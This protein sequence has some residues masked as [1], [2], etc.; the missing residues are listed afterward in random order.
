MVDISIVIVNYK[1]WN[2]LKE[3]LQSIVSIN[4]NR[5]TMETIVVDNQSNDG[6]IKELKTLFPSIIFIENLGN[7][8]L[9]NGCNLGESIAK[10]NYFFFLN[11]D[12]IITEAAIF[13]LWQ[14]ATTHPDF[15]IV[16]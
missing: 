11:Q 12:T 8:G 4:S 2:D 5:F 1:S 7:N 3:C 10:E 6:R 9:A 13:E 16:C 14:T 15:G